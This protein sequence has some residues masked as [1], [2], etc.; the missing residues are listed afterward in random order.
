M[1]YQL[2]IRPEAAA[3]LADA[4][5]WYEQRKAGLGRDLLARIESKLEEIKAHPG[6]F[7]VVHRDIRRALIRRFPYGIYFFA[8][9]SALIVIAIF[10]AKRNP[11]RWKDRR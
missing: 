3:D 8:H 4:F 6:R 10:H 5:E 2:I 9:G 7:P 11:Q 1:N